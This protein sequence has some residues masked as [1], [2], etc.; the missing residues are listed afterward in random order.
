MR[1]TMLALRRHGSGGFWDRNGQSGREIRMCVEIPSIGWDPANRDELAGSAPQRFGDVPNSAVRGDRDVENAA[2]ERRV[3]R[4]AKMRIRVNML[5][6]AG[7]F[8]NL[9]GAAMENRY[10]VT[11]FDQTQRQERAG[12]ASAANNQCFFH[13][14]STRTKFASRSIDRPQTKIQAELPIVSG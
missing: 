14:L 6:F 3:Q 11:A 9:V 8:R 10:G 7:D 12:R 13:A 1:E 2:F 5:D 4:F